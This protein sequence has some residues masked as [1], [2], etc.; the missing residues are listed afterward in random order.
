MKTKGI[1]SG[2]YSEKKPKRK[3]NLPMCPTCR[4]CKDRSICQNRKKLKYCEVCKKCTDKENCD[5]FYHYLRGRALLTIGKDIETREPI[6]KLFTGDT[7]E[8]ALEN[9]YKYKIAIKE[10]GNDVDNIIHKTTKSIADIGQEIEDSK[11]RKGKTKGNAYR[12]NMATL[13]RIK[14]NNFANIPIDKVKKTQI[15]N[16]LEKE[17]VKSNSVIKKDYTMLKR[18]F[19]NAFDNRYISNNLFQGINLIEKPKSTKEDK[20]V[21][22]LSYKEQNKFVNYLENNNVKHKNILLICLYTGMRIGEVLALNYKEDIDLDSMQITVRRTLTKNKEGKTI[23]GPPKTNSG[24]RILQIN[25]LTE[26]VLKDS[27][28]NIKKNKNNVLF[29]HSDGKLIETNTIN[30]HFKRVYKNAG[31]SGNYSVHCLRHTYAT[32]CIEAG[33]ELPVLQALMGHADIQTTINAYGDIYKYLEV[34]NH[35]KYVDYVK[36]GRI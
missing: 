16:F 30:S 13:N 4:K 32:R 33:V 14:S 27:L 22:A 18:I 9:L 11:F 2:V 12:T 15:E 34:Q 20:D 10:S 25:E 3:S 31:I 7:E 36:N 8:E 1:T 19:E 17:R 5:K 29:C 21:K 35:K 28:Q 23:V 26:K 24:K 6:R